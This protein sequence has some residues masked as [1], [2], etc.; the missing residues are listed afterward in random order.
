MKEHILPNDIVAQY[1]DYDQGLPFYLKHR[2]VLIDW[3][4]ELDF[5][6]KRGDQSDWFLDTPGFLERYW[7][8][9]ERVLLVVREEQSLDFL[10]AT[11][12][13]PVILV[14]GNGKTVV[15][16]KEMNPADE[17]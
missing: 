10:N 9:D 14:E 3:V 6:S 13:S 7:I 15:T 2:I 4:G 12:V 11:G 1:R 17:K 5:G 8:S 16:N